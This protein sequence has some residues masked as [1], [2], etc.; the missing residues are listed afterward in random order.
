MLESLG[1]EEGEL[2]PCS[3]K[4][5]ISIQEAGFQMGI[6]SIGVRSGLIKILKERDGKA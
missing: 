5:K 3:I 4:L 2:N 6:P 1:D